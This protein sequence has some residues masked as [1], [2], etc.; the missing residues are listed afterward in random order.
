MK[1]IVGKVALA[2]TFICAA[3]PLVRGAQRGDMPFGYGARGLDRFTLLPGP[4][5]TS[6]ARPFPRPEPTSI[7]AVGEPLFRATPAEST[8]SPTKA[9][10]PKAESL[11]FQF[12]MPATPLSLP[13]KI[14]PAPKGD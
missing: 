1:T 13:I 11:R 14:T 4:E 9:P 6:P 7:R 2:A 3:L 10:T 12:F 5:L 8:T